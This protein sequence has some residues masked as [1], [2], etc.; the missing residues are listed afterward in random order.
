MGRQT[1]V[2]QSYSFS[3]SNVPQK[4]SRPPPV[5]QDA[6]PKNIKFSAPKPSKPP[7]KPPPRRQTLNAHKRQRSGPLPPVK[8]INE[9]SQVTVSSPSASPPTK[10][11]PTPPNVAKLKN[12]NKRPPK[13]PVPIPQTK[14]RAKTHSVPKTNHVT[15]K[16]NKPSTTPPK[17]EQSNMKKPEGATHR[18]QGSRLN[19]LAGI[20]SFKSGSLKH[21]DAETLQKQAAEN[22]SNVSG[23][24]A[25]T[26]KN[27][28]QFVMDDDDGSD[29]SDG[30]WDD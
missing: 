19:M 5:P 7:S 2:S 24:L 23:L 27:Y 11:A 8:A 21:V 30:S 20:T 26:L 9:V 25:S 6:T 18:K 10:I 14:K 17:I 13:S 29:D 3:N 22:P 4:P 1:S 12:V 28:R 16:E 15:I